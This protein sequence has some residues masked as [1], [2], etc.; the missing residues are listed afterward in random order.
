MQTCAGC[1]P[2]Q[3]SQFTTS[4]HSRTLAHTRDLEIAKTLDGESFYDS[5]LKQTYE[6]RFDAQKGL[7]VKIREKPGSEFPLQHAL[8]SGT[9]GMTFVGISSFPRQDGS[10]RKAAIEHHVTIYPQSRKRM[11]ITPGHDSREIV[12]PSSEFGNPLDDNVLHRCFDCHSTTLS[13]KNL[14]LEGLVANVTCERCH[15]PGSL[16]VAAAESGSKTPGHLR[17]I[18]KSYTAEQQLRAC[19][20]CHR[21]PDPGTSIR[22]DD[23]TSV[24]FQPLGLMQSRCYLESRGRLTC[25]TCHNPHQGTSHDEKG[26]IA[27]C[28]KCHEQGKAE[29][30]HCKVSPSADCIRCHMPA[31]RAVRNI[32]FT[33]HW[34]R[35]RDEKDPKGVHSGESSP[36]EK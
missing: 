10:L 31:V 23:A 15:G 20:K 22:A 8:G 9:Q 7:S 18:P 4:G 28:L 24:R 21:F 27:A 33:D 13:V 32:A 17:L 35:I 6:Y 2:D 11:D 14:E 12:R 29:F 5:E 3:H 30:S 36:K 26:Y 1:H 34:I 16:H 19:G 25:T